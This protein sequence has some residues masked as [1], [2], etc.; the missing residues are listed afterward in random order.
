[1][2]KPDD[3][4]AVVVNVREDALVWAIA[5]EMALSM[6]NCV[7]LLVPMATLTERIAWVNRWSQPGDLAVEVHLNWSS[8]PDPAGC[9]TFYAGSSA[10]GREL[11]AQL[12]AGLVRIGRSPR[13][14]K[15]DAESAR[16]RL[17][18]CRDTRPW[19]AL[20]EVS[21]LTNEQELHWILHGGTIAAGRALA[22]AVDRMP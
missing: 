12:H 20:V 22:G 3:P 14:V 5:D 16:K 7:P 15:S 2:T 19:A 9:E 6:A 18:W 1:M 8:S 4:G 21:F 13:G 17:A 10:R 11:A